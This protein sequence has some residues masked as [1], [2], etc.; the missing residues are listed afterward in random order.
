[1]LVDTWPMLV[2]MLE[3]QLVFFGRWFHANT[4]SAEPDPALWPIA[5]M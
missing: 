1:M 3:T 4:H 5:N 2:E